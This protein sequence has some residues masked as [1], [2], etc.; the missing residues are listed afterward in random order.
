MRGIRSFAS[1]GG[2]QSVDDGIARD[3]DA[4]GINSL[5][6]KI[7]GGAARWRTMDR[8]RQACG[9]SV[10]LLGPGCLQIAC[11]QTRLDV[12]EWNPSKKSDHGTGQ[13]G[14]CVPLGDNAIRLAV[15]DDRIQA[16][17]AAGHERRWRLARRHQVQVDVGNEAEVVRDLA[18]HFAVLTGKTNDRIDDGRSPTTLQDH[19]RHFD[20]FWP[21]A[22]GQQ[23]AN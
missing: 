9:A 13:N 2:Q 14:R 23:H 3:V 16:G 10:E 17:K 5:G 4:A 21:G 11:A 8:R 20:A 12:D 22:Q 18:Q 1:D 15:L 7:V 6:Q 19:G